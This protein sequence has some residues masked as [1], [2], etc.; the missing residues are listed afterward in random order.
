MRRASSSIDY[1]YYSRRELA[2]NDLETESDQSSS[3]P[4]LNEYFYE[5]D[6]YDDI[7]DAEAYN[8]RRE[9]HR[10]PS[11]TCK[12]SQMRNLKVYSLIFDN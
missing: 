4:E 7:E 8:Y 11:V 12:L 3:N 5:D 2:N 10:T 9:R 6:S 1:D